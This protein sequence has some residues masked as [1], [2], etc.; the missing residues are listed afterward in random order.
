MST[1]KIGQIEEHELFIRFNFL[2][3]RHLSK[4]VR[5]ELVLAFLGFVV[6]KTNSSKIPGLKS[7]Y[8]VMYQSKCAIHVMHKKAYSPYVKFIWDFFA[9][10]S[11]R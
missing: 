1:Y 4:R 9:F 11:L 10:F 3:L 8:E 7:Y 2:T 6:M 5:P